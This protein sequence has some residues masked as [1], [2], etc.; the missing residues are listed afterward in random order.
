MNIE[1][2]ERVKSNFS[3]KEIVKIVKLVI[4]A[5]EFKQRADLGI[6]ISSSQEM[7][8]LNQLYRHKNK[9]AAVL[10]FSY[11]KSKP[12]KKEVLVVPRNESKFLGEVFLC[13]SE[14][15]QQA[16]KYSL[17]YYQEFARLLIHGLLHLLGYTHQTKAAEKRMRAREEK[18]I[19]KVLT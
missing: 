9:S 11:L 12:P 15:V 1:I 6:V 14:I 3:Q 10:S 16:K 13:P 19:S 5:A 4:K 2:T 8:K 17:T 7:K 18:V